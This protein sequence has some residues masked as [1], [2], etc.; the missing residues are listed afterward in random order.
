MC[1]NIAMA[2]PSRSSDI[3]NLLIIGTLFVS[4]YALSVQPIIGRDTDFWWHLASGREAWEK[5]AIV[6]SDPFS[7]TASGEPWL[8]YSWAFGSTLYMLYHWTGLDG[9]IL[10]RSFLFLVAA[11][12][13][14]ITARVRGAHILSAAVAALLVLMLQSQYWHIRPHF[15][16]LCIAILIM[17]LLELSIQGRKKLLW[18]IPPLTVLWVNFHGGVAMIAPVLVFT[19]ACGELLTRTGLIKRIH[20]PGV[21]SQEIESWQKVLTCWAPLLIVTTGALMIHPLLWRPLSYVLACSFIPSLNKILI[22]EAGT[23]DFFSPDLRLSLVFMILTIIS[24]LVLAFRGRYYDLLLYVIFSMLMFSTVRFHYLLLP[25][26][27][28]AIACFLTLLSLELEKH[29]NLRNVLPACSFILFLLLP[30]MLFREMTDGLRRSIPPSRLVRWETLPYGAC[31]FLKLNAIKGNLFNAFDWGGYLIWALTPDCR[32]FIDP[33]VNQ[34]YSEQFLKEYMTILSGTQESVELFKKSNADIII[35]AKEIDNDAFFTTLI[36]SDNAWSLI[37]EDES[38][39][40]YIRKDAFPDTVSTNGL[41][42]SSFMPH[43][44]KGKTFLAQRNFPAAVKEL[45]KAVE[46][47]P[48]CPRSRIYLG[49][50]YASVG[51]LARAERQWKLALY[52]HPQAR[53]AYYYLGQASLQQGNTTRAAIYLA[54]EKRRNPSFQEAGQ[55]LSTLP[56]VNP[57]IVTMAIGWMRLWAPLTAW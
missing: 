32:V 37:Y 54:E 3:L 47:Y 44:M 51:D 36:P 38:A 15:V 5:G 31:S 18:I 21:A 35:R 42:D 46:L 27:A 26:L 23:P 8:N 20:P 33:R 45:E 13:F 52:I 12:L 55:I 1:K 9:C 34:L 41:P 10:F 17:L 53:L 39:M 4:A 57:F 50:A 16:S 14:F 30:V 11:A 28:P 40:I 25:L 49:G 56:P 43:L 7:H 29:D 2:R 48:D 24:S 22:Q 19:Y 6:T